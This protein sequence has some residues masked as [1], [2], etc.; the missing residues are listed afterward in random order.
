MRGKRGLKNIR[1]DGGGNQETLLNN[2]SRTAKNLRTS[3]EFENRV[4]TGT[5]S[6][7]PCLLSYR[8]WEWSV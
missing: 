2:C 4:R 3:N 5:G 1:E 7:H 6:T 8:A